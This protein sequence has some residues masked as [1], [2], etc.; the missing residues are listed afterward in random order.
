MDDEERRR[1]I[2]ELPEEMRAFVENL[3]E[4]ELVQ[5]MDRDPALNFLIREMYPDPR[6]VMN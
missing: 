6:A 1:L 4:T 2:G 3:L 5:A